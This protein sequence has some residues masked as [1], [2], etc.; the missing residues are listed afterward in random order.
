MEWEVF[1]SGRCPQC[2]EDNMAA[3]RYCLPECEYFSLLVISILTLKRNSK[4]IIRPQGIFP[5]IKTSNQKIF[6]ANYDIKSWTQ[7][8]TNG[9]PSWWVQG[10]I[11]VKIICVLRQ[12]GINLKPPIKS[13]Q[14]GMTEFNTLLWNS[15]NTTKK[16]KTE[17]TA[18]LDFKTYFK[19]IRSPK[20]K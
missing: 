16:W 5:R 6:Q 9:K 13:D 8:R 20:F 4:Y 17:I 12:R 3:N 11:S 14:N 18:H 19:N 2:W 10:F 7:M 15:Q 1:I